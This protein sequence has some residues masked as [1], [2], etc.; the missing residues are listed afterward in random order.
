MWLPHVSL[1]SGGKILHWPRI[2]GSSAHPSSV[3]EHHRS[4]AAKPGAA[5][6]RVD[7]DEFGY[8]CFHRALLNL[9]PDV[10]AAG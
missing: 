2:D 1:F 3:E 9:G 8:G 10:R 4:S 7:K 6:E 5:S